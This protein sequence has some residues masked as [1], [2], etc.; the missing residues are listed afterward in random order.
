MPWPVSAGRCLP[1]QCDVGGFAEGEEEVEF[2]GEEGVV[3]FELEAEEGEGLDEG[4]AAGDDFGAAV[5]D[6]VEGGEFLEDA[7]GV[8][9]AEDGDGGGEADGFGA[10]GCGGEDDGG[11]GVEV[12]GA[13]M[14]AEAEDVEANF[15]GEL[16]LFEEVGDALLRGDDVA[17]DGVGTRA[18]KLSMPICIFVFLCLI[19]SHGLMRICTDDTDLMRR[20]RIWGGTNCLNVRV[21]K[22]V[23]PLRCAPIEMTAS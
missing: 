21:E 15:V 6:E 17:G 9:G 3:V 23:S 19:V 18:A 12:L 16:D 14:L 10:G 4:A 5:G 11:G 20:P 22:R 1:D 8:G 2:F 13:V 7:D